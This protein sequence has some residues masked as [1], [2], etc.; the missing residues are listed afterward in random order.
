V[1][2]SYFPFFIPV[3]CASFLLPVFRSYFPFLIHVLCVSFLLPVFRSYFPFL[4]PVLR[5]SFLLSVFHSYTSCIS[6]LYF[7][8]FIP[9]F[10]FLLVIPVLHASFLL[11]GFRS[12]FPDKSKSKRILKL[13]DCKYIKNGFIIY[14]VNLTI[15]FNFKPPVF[16]ASF[17]LSVCHSYLRYLAPTFHFSILFSES[18]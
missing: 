2:R 3:F 1:F 18:Y 7:L 6:F 11:P 9:T 14:K 13:N 4:I 17:L 12:Y 10:H 16:R 5:A 15:E 8:Y